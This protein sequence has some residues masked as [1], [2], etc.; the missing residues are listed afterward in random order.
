VPFGAGASLIYCLRNSLSYLDMPR[1]N[2]TVCTPVMSNT[3]MYFVLSA[4]FG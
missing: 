4:V 1:T 2:V 3:V